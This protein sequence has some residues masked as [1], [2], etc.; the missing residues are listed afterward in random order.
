M[1]IIRNLILLLSCTTATL[2]AALAKNGQIDNI[3]AIV[4]QEVILASDIKRMRTTVLSHYENENTPL[5]SDQEL[6]TQ[7]LDK[8]ID[9]TLQLQIADRIGL[10]IN[11]A[12]LDQT[13]QQIAKEK[14]LTVSQ[15]QSDIEGKGLSYAA[16][17]DEV[18]NELTINETRQIQVR[19]RINISDQ[20]VEQ[21][22]ARL[23]DHGEKNTKFHFIHLMLRIP[24]DSSVQQQQEITEQA[25]KLLERV[26][27]GENI[28]NLAVKYSQGPKALE[29]G[30]WGWR[31]IDEIPSVFADSFDDRKT[32]KG[33]IIGPVR[34]SVG[35]HIIEVVGKQGSANVTTT[36]VNARHIL[37]KSN[38]ILSDEKA[39]ELLIDYRQEIISGKESFAELANEHS[40]DP[41]S[42][43]KGGELGWA[44][45]SMYV[46]EF[47]DISLS[48]PIGEIS[49]PFRTMH[50]W[51]I[52]EV[53]DR[54]ESD[55]TEQATKQKAYGILYKQRFPAEAYAWLNELR[56]EA[57]IKIMNPNY[58]MKAK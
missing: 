38:I 39:K 8:L 13:I 7:I 56:Q 47:R 19:R 36:E 25:N 23:N 21:M 34:S 48:L 41:G 27:S 31:S 2:P 16:F 28:S 44:D 5:P 10:R 20:E 55:T 4:N 22:V 37:I 33:D 35:L 40:Q 46:P 49:Q 18:R 51:H 29:G 15:L 52:L 42:A 9:D 6:Q 50:G 57:Y 32:Q 12:Q 24:S 58:V 43:I 11:D 3:E 17:V 54:R 14:G 30:D 26:K 45:P 53:M 1:K